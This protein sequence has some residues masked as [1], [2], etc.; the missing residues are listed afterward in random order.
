MYS[1]PYILYVLA[2]STIALFT[3][4]RVVLPI[5]YWRVVLYRYRVVI[6]ILTRSTVPLQSCTPYDDEYLYRYRVVLPIL[7]RSTVPLQ[8]LYSLYWR[9][10][11]YRYRVVRYPTSYTDEEYPTVLLLSCTPYTDEENCTVTELYW[12]GVPVLSVLA[13]CT[14]PV[15]RRFS[16]SFLRSRCC[17]PTYKTKNCE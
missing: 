13:R 4:Y 9:G 3:F 14:T 12:R 15:D 10:V 11:L 7:T 17:F 6:P 2:W 16:R 8:E 5:R 1:V